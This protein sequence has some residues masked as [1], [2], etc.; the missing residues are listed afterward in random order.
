MAETNDILARYYPLLEKLACGKGGFGALEA[1]RLGGAL[2][3]LQ[4]GLTGDRLLAG[5]SYF[6]EVDFLATYLLYYWPVSFIQTYLALKEIEARGALPRIVNV[7]DLGAGPGPSSFAAAE[8]GAENFLLV[9]ANPKVLDS[10][11]RLHELVAD[12][13]SK[14]TIAKKDFEKDES[15]PNGSYD[16]I[17][18]SHSMN[19]LWKGQSDA[20]RRRSILLEKACD[21]LSDGGILLVIEPSALSTSRPALELRDL[22]LENLRDV[23]MSC[24]APC[25]GSYP[26]PIMKAGEGRSCHSTWK[27]IP[28][29]AAAT[30][31]REAGLDRDSVKATWFALKKGRKAA[32]NVAQAAPTAVPA[33]PTAPVAQAAA[34]A[35]NKGALAGRVV[36][37]SMLNK[38]GRVRYIVCTDAGLATISAR[39]DDSNALRSGFLALARGDCVRA[40]GLE[41]RSGEN[42]FGYAA[43]SSLEITLKAPR[44]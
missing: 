9:D 43:D 8:L 15:W 24:V 34:P 22:L 31:A 32:A 27:W 11:L 1:R 3:N 6:S 12:T 44:A 17:V 35:P 29:G 37:E 26:C 39:G 14:F 20:L 16:L 7:L 5:A 13:R 42:G 25:P 36:S 28:T 2:K 21:S 38:S 23:G 4:R 40:D 19:E 41:R 33:L 18:A 10:A 30:L